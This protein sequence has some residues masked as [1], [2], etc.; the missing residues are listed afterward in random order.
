[1][2]KQHERFVLKQFFRAANLD[3]EIVDDRSEAPDF[4]VKLGHELVGIEITE[5]FVTGGSD[6]KNLQAQESLA[7]R[8][9]S[10]A[11]RLYQSSGGA[12]AH[13]SV[14]FAPRAD[15]RSLNRDE[16]AAALSAFVKAQTFA[17]NELLQWHQDYVSKVLPDAITYVQV[18]GVP[19]NRMAH[20]TVPKAGWV[21]PLTET[22]LQARI[23]EKA[24]LLPTYAR[25]V[26]TNWLLLVA[27]GGQP[28]Q[29]F[30]GPSAETASTVSTPFARTFYFARMRGAVVELGRPRA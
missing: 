16:T 27:D 22:V 8:I 9:V 12:H 7:H 10:K 2:K 18:L 23:D 26:P 15:L 17:V 11:K 21:V 20:W 24:A 6:A 5:L 29:F 25:R 28:S 3:G 30:D 4:I 19:E 14:H 1:M 13:V